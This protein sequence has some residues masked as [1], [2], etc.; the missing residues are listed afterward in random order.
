MEISEQI[1]LLR[2]AL[3]LTRKELAHL[4][5]LSVD[6]VINIEEHGIVKNREILLR[7]L[8]DR[9]AEA[10]ENVESIAAAIKNIE[11][12]KGEN[13]DNGRKN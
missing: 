8:L 11:F 9:Q 3:N 7:Y 4:T 12:E 1:K 5:D 2:R 13:E 10:I 6:T